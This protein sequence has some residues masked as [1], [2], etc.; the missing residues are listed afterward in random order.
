MLKTKQ[1]IALANLV[2]TAVMGVRRLFGKGPDVI[3]KDNFD[4]F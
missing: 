1:K 3:R 4:S 2:Q